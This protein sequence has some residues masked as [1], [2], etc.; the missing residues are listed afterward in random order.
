MLF[1]YVISFSSTNIPVELGMTILLDLQVTSEIMLLVV[2]DLGSVLSLGP[3]KYI[4]HNCKSKLK[5]LVT[6]CLLNVL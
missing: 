2:M 5:F 4:F 1:K 6:C 3:T